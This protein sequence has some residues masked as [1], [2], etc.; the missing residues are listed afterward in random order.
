MVKFLLFGDF[1]FFGFYGGDIVVGFEWV[2]GQQVAV[3]FQLDVR[4]IGVLVEV[5]GGLFQLGMFDLVFVGGGV[6]D[7]DMELFGVEF[8]GGGVVGGY[9]G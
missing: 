9:V 8:L 6:F 5:F 3:V 2:I 7:G 4:V 1:D